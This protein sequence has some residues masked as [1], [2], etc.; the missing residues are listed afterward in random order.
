MEQSQE[1]EQTTELVRSFIVYFSS[2]RIFGIHLFCWTTALSVGLYFRSG[3]TFYMDF[4]WLNF[5]VSVWSLGDSGSN[6]RSA[7]QKWNKRRVRTCMRGTRTFVHSFIRTIPL[8]GYGSLKWNR[9]SVRA[10]VRETRT[11]RSFGLMCLICCLY[12][13]FECLDLLKIKG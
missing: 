10:C 5:S 1:T 12:Y 2:L 6:P 9:G 3:V 7:L 4:V 11:F 8:L 13:H